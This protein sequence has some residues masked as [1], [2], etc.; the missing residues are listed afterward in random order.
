MPEK[1][2]RKYLLYGSRTI[3]FAGTPGQNLHVV[4]LNRLDGHR[5]LGTAKEVLPGIYSYICRELLQE[6]ESY[7]I[8][9]ADG[10]CMETGVLEPVDYEKWQDTRFGKLGMLAGKREAQLDYQYAELTDLA[11]ALFQPIEE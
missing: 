8:Q 7:E 6:P 3:C 10:S 11:D 5:I 2:Q 1:L 4:H 9:T